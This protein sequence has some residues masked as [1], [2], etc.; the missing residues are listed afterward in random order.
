MLAL[1]G[2][3]CDCCKPVKNVA[4][5]YQRVFENVMP[6]LNPG[7]FYATFNFT[8]HIGLFYLRCSIY[9]V[10]EVVSDTGKKED[11]KILKKARSFSPISGGFPSFATPYT[12]PFTFSFSTFRQYYDFFKFAVNNFLPPDAQNFSPLS[13]VYL[14]N[15]SF[16]DLL[17][18][19]EAD[20][21]KYIDILDNALFLKEFKLF[22][23]SA[24]Y[25]FNTSYDDSKTWEL[26][27]YAAL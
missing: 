12:E 1:I 7:T 2:A 5:T 25:M 22:D 27:K 20:G 16:N 11:I 10:Y 19:I 17:A 9:D 23:F 3:C 13:G 6:H 26:P 4:V 14:T 24:E 8:I 21:E 15:I 18:R